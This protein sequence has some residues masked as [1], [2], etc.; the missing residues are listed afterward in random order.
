MKKLIVVIVVVLVAGLLAYKFLM[1]KE[2]KKEGP[3]DQPLAIGRNTSVF[4]TA[5]GGFLDEYFALKDALVEWDTAKADK[6]AYDLALKADSL[7][8][9]SQLKA[10]S[11]VVLTA[12]S[13]AASVSGEAKGLVG[14]GGIEQ[15]RRGFNMLTDEIYN[16]IRTVRYD[17]EKIYHIK[18]PMAFNDS[19]E[20]FWLSSSTDVINPYLGKHHPKYKATMVGCGEVSDSL[21]FTKH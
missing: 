16:L 18:C 9:R 8:I 14:E 20:G 17:G 12:V 21:D 6:A 2:E 11:N 5:F 19:E 15:K 10:D 1:P 7:P 13:L 3:K 4:N